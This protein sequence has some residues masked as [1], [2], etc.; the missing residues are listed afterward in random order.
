METEPSKHAVNLLL[1]RIKIFLSIESWLSQL[2]E[3]RVRKYVQKV[4]SLYM[5]V[6]P[7]QNPMWL[8]RQCLGD[9]GRKESLKLSAFSGKV[10]SPHHLHMFN[11]WWKT[12]STGLS[13]GSD[14]GGVGASSPPDICNQLHLVPLP[15]WKLL[16]YIESV[17]YHL[18]G[19]LY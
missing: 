14:S 6:I 11:V 19:K 8:M 15:N 5:P 16:D 12:T 1:L 7:V 10:D 3:R 17:S 2:D 18:I 13:N 4:E 9:G